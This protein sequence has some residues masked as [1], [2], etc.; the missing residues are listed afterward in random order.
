[1][2]GLRQRTMT[3]VIGLAALGLAVALGS[4]VRP[5]GEARADGPYVSPHTSGGSGTTD[6]CAAC[7]R[8]HTGQARELLKTASP[9]STLCFTCHGSAAPGAISN[10]EAEYSAAGVGVNNPTT[11]SYYTHAA[12]ATGS[13][14][15]TAADKYEFG[16]PAKLNRHSECSDCHNSHAAS[17]AAL[18][19]PAANSPW[20]VSGALAAI[21]GVDSAVRWKNPITLE[22]ELCL[23]CHSNYT[24]LPAG[25]LDKAAELVGSSFHPIAQKGT[26]ATAAM[27]A[28]LQGGTRYNT[29]T[30]DSTIRCTQCHSNNTGAGS[31]AINSAPTARL[32]PHASANRGILAANYRDRNLASGGYLQGDFALCFLCHDPAPFGFG[33]G[34]PATATNFKDGSE[35]LHGKHVS[36]FGN[37]SG[38]SI[39]A[40]IGA[41]VNAICSECHFSLHSTALS[42]GNAGLITFAPSVSGYNGSGPSWTRTSTGGSCTLTCHGEQHEP[43][44]YGAGTSSRTASPGLTT[45]G[46][47]MI[48]TTRSIEPTPT[49]TTASGPAPTPTP[50]PPAPL[51]APAPVPTTLGNYVLP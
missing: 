30:V 44:S 6:T 27:T 43:E 32:A 48:R 12:T 11:S 20:G 45:T 24:V 3:T 13:N 31:G 42:G 7:H 17:I 41:E 38:Q 35:N 25:A 36:G 22:Y 18:A 37:G 21:S 46:G 28:S 40:P 39:A 10:V 4:I 16:D 50:P 5:G 26:N 14:H 1:M 9:Q 29:L 51:T 2:T 19:Q 33:E 8:T 15:T 47:T 49:P 23:K 34:S